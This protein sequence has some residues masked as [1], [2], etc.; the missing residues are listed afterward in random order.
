MSYF[1][2]HNRT[3]DILHKYSISIVQF[4]TSKYFTPSVPKYQLLEEKLVVLIRFIYL[5]HGC[6][7]ADLQLIIIITHVLLYQTR[8]KA[9]LAKLCCKNFNATLVITITGKGMA[10]KHCML[11]V[12]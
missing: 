3:L 4:E 6:K 9:L 8:C 2:S 7:K 11:V 10:I 12:M 1:L 5:N